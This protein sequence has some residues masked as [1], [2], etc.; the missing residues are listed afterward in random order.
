[1]TNILWMRSGAQVIEVYPS[2]PNELLRPGTNVNSFS[3][4]GRWAS[5]VNASHH[6]LIGPFV[7]DASSWKNNMGEQT[8]NF[9]KLD[10]HIPVV[11]FQQV[12]QEAWSHL[13]HCTIQ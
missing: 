6:V 13:F 3:D 9:R 2:S 4:Y 5:I 1:M 7:K 10:A 8:S 11:F 12:L